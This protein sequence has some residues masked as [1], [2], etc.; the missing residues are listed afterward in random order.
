MP[1]RKHLATAER[2]ALV[3][4]PV[5]TPGLELLGLVDPDDANIEALGPHAEAR[6]AELWSRWHMGQAAQGLGELAGHMSGMTTEDKAG[7]LS[8]LAAALGGQ[9]GG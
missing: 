8:V 9:D 7:L 3:L 6:A 1:R 2:D 4:A 5:G